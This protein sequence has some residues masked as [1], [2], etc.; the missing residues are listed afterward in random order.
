MMSCS[1]DTLLHGVK[2]P[3]LRRFS[4]WIDDGE[5]LGIFLITHPD[6]ESVFLGTPPPPYRQATSAA[7]PYIM[8]VLG[9]QYRDKP[10]F[11]PN[12]RVLG[13]ISHVPRSVVPK[14]P[15]TALSIAFLDDP[16]QAC[17]VINSTLAVLRQST[18]SVRMLHVSFR[19]WQDGYLSGIVRAAPDILNLRLISCGTAV[20]LPRSHEMVELLKV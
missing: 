18:T 10:H 7:L 5:R 11:L 6:L 17:S 12:L 3:R 16:P 20:T 15:V 4:T 8:D 14:R 2:L 19:T 9:D 1:G 13:C